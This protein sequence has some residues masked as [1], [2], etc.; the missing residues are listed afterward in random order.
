MA[1]EYLV[2]VVY[3]NTVAD[4]S[5][6]SVSIAPDDT[7]MELNPH[8]RQQSPLQQDN[9]LLLPSYAKAQS[10]DHQAVIVEESHDFKR[11]KE[12]GVTPIH[13]MGIPMHKLSR[14]V[15]FFVCSLG[16]LFFYLLYG[17]SQV[18]QLYENKLSL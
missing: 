5:P 4:S 9:S 8:L 11:E 1:S 18:C 14:P 17:Y 6:V 13:I 7:G 2:S 3:L 10:R 15:Q 12:G 16:I